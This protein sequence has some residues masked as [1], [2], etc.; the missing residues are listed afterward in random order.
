VRIIR[1]Y[2]LRRIMS[3][4]GI[5]LGVLLGLAVFIEFVGQLDD[6][7][8]GGYGILQALLYA[9]MKLPNLAHVMLPMAVLLGA[10]MGLGGLAN[11]SELIA[12]RAAGVSMQRLAGA[13][14]ITGMIL[15][16]IALVLSEYVGP[17]LE[18]YARQFRTEAKLGRT[19]I[20]S[21]TN[22]WMRD[23]GTIMNIRLSEDFR[24]SGVFLFEMDAAG[25]L[26]SIGRADSAGIDDDNQWVLNNHAESVFS[27]NGVTTH[28]TRRVSHPNNL[29][30]D[31][32]GLAVVR[33]D[34]L[35]GVALYRY[36]RYL[37][38]SG[39]D[40]RRYAVAFWGRIA[41]AVAVT[42]M[43]VLALP[44]VFGRMRSAGTGARMIVGLM[45]GLVYFLAARSLADGGQVYQLNALLIAWL[46][47]IV[48]SA[49]TVVAVTK[50]R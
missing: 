29:S 31:L 23:G 24:S 8:S 16:L 19:G 36:V 27:D 50:S 48:L 33:P 41:S 12:I 6:V 43:C 25:G 40:A 4:T 22:T 13:V 49:V 45:I 21:D 44:F 5:V 11:N 1:R 28:E 15:S 17:P 39:L 37:E 32:V 46:P 47:T 20:T 42:P 30:P 35:S 10:L 3:M 9:A 18:K 2:L 7:G 34:S 26:T 14:M 38:Q